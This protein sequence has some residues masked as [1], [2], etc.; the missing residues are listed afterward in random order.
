MGTEQT[1][2]GS[3]DK[4]QTSSLMVKEINSKIAIVDFL[5]EKLFLQQ[6]NLL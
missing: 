6:K 3:F 5:P 2:E 4:V 1:L